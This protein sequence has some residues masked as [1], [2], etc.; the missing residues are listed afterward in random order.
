MIGSLVLVLLALAIGFLTGYRWRRYEAQ[1]LPEQT[2][3]NDFEL[4]FATARQLEAKLRKRYPVAGGDGP[5]VGLHAYI[6]QAAYRGCP[7]S[8]ITQFR[9][10]ATIRN[11]MA[12]DAAF[13]L[14]SRTRRQ[15]YRSAAALKKLP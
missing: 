5:G 13:R 15:F 4:V 12:H 8:M 6:T 9:F 2:G 10:L 1:F 3:L 7:E 11:R 14:N